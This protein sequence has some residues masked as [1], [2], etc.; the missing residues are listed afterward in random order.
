MGG[1]SPAGMARAPRLPLPLPPGK[2]HTVPGAR[3][4]K[5]GPIP[6]YTGTIPAYRNHVIGHGYSDGARRA[7]ALTDS[8]RHN[9]VETAYHLVC[10]FPFHSPSFLWDSSHL[11][12]HIVN[13]SLFFPA[14]TPATN[15][16]AMAEAV[17]R[18]RVV[19]HGFGV[20]SAVNFVI[21]Q[22]TENKVEGRNFFYA[23][24]AHAG[25]VNDPAPIRW[26]ASK[27]ETP[28]D[29][30]Y[31]SGTLDIRTLRSLCSIK[32]PQPRSRSNYCIHWTGLCPTVHIDFDSLVSQGC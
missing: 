24:L 18:S 32:L 23:Q 27:R 12:S 7:A 10:T 6:G 31:C 13:A 16:L 1:D 21:V 25:E 4:G 29:M 8:L 26:Q 9:R 20:L 17:Y 3:I 14:A 2:M 30:K 19:S 11:D 22:S 28:D 15:S 5:E